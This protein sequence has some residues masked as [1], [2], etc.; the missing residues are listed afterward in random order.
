[1]GMRLRQQGLRNDHWIQFE[2][3]EDGLTDASYFA[4]VYQEACEIIAFLCKLYGIDPNGT[5]DYNG[6]KVPTILC[7]ADSHSYDAA[8]HRQDPD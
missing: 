1:M 4:K 6:L 3:C 2:I 7:H 8:R 5:V